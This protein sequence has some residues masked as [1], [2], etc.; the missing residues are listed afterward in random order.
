MSP[1][2]DHDTSRTIDVLAHFTGRRP[3]AVLLPPPRGRLCATLWRHS[4][5]VRRL[6]SPQRHILGIALSGHSHVE[7]IAN[8][9]SVWRGPAFGSII[10]VPR[11]KE[12]D[13]RLDGSFQQLQIYL[14]LDDDVA[15]RIGAHTH[16]PFR[17][18]VLLRLAQSIALA[19]Q[20][21][22]TDARYLS[23]ALEA[24][25]QAFIARHLEGAMR[26][27]SEPAEGGLSGAC[28][29]RIETLIEARIGERITV[30]DLAHETP[31][32]LGHFT[33]AFRQ[34]YGVSP[35]Q[36]LTNRRIALAS[37]LLRETD[38]PIREI[39]EASGFASPSHFGAVFRSETGLSPMAYRRA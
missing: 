28:R 26:D 18:G 6:S 25:Q 5:T 15:E 29:M 14:D 34:S 21:G 30:R 24:L 27:G 7:Q 39:A 8:G 35:H 2:M 16:V 36:Y 33:R 13:W 23:P 31:L 37:Q 10:L 9:R 12:T 3:D 20:E 32:S 17:D 22:C 11:G 4:P 19:A 1:G 38:R